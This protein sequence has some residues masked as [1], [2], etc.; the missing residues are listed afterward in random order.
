VTGTTRRHRDAAEIRKLFVYG[1]VDGY[2]EPSSL[3]SPRNSRDEGSDRMDDRQPSQTALAAAA[4]RAAHLVVDQEPLIFRDPVAAGL[5]G[6]PGAEMVGYHQRSGDHIVLAGTRAQV[7]V[8]SRYTEQR[9]AELTD[10]G[11][12]QYVLLGAGLDSFAYRSPLAPG[13][14]IFEVDHPA[15]Q[16]WKRQLLAAAHLTPPDGLNLV[17][18]TWRPRRR[19]TAW[20]PQGS[21]RA[22]R[23]W[24]AGS[25]SVCTS[26]PRPSPAPWPRSVAW[27]PAA[28]W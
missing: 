16:R 21:T 24:S 1:I 10:R 14:R 12:D 6:E 4:A 17:G 15:S 5:I 18:V 27:P 9:L 23:P 11:L 13:L 2:V 7:T 25:G 19:S 26:P 22:G 8:R 3:T 28:S 20:P